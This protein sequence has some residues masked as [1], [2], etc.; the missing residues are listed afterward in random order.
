LL[1]SPPPCRRSG[2]RLLQA[3]RRSLYGSAINRQALIGGAPR[4]RPVA[5]S[6][7]KIRA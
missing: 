6:A 2:A 7:R 3:A 5:K 1:H 4:V